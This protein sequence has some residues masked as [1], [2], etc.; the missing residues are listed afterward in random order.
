M[1]MATTSNRLPKDPELNGLAV[2]LFHP[3]MEMKGPSKHYEFPWQT[4]KVLLN[5][6]A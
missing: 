6:A 3:I 2:F 4:R 1:I 5:A